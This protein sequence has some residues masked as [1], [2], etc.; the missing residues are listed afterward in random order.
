MGVILFD[1]VDREVGI[2]VSLEEVISFEGFNI[3]KL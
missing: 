3:S 1:F 2:L